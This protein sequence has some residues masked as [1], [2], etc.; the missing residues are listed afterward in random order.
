MASITVTIT[1]DDGTT[2][3]HTE[4]LGD[5]SAGA[6]VE[7]MEAEYDAEVDGQPPS[8]GTSVSRAVAQVIKGWLKNYQALQVELQIKGMG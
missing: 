1:R 7:W 2:Y 5:A 6:I 3:D 4:T 8:T